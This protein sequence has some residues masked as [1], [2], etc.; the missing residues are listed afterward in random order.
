MSGPVAV[1][2]PTA[3]ND[4]TSLLGEPMD[5]RV[6]TLLNGIG[7]AQLSIQMDAVVNDVD[8]PNY[9]SFESGEIIWVDTIGGAG[10]DTFILTDVSHRGVLG[11]T[12]QPH[13]ASTDAVLGITAET[14]RQLQ[15]AVKAAQ[16]NGFLIGTEAAK[17]GTCLPGEGYLAYDVGKVYVC[18][19]ANTWVWLNQVSHT[20]TT[21]RADD[22]HAQYHTDGR[23][24]TWHG[25]IAED[26][27]VAGDNH[28]HYSANEGPAVLRV[29]GGTEAGKPAA[30]TKGEIYFSTDLD[31][32]TL[33]LSPDGSSWQ[34]ISGMPTGAIGAFD[35]ACPLGWTRFTNLDG[36][37]VRI[38]AAAGGSGGALSHEHDYSDFEQ[39]L[40]NIPFQ[41]TGVTSV[42]SSSHNHSVLHGSAG[43]GSGAK[44][45]QLNV[46][47][48]QN[49]ENSASHT[50]AS[51]LPA[52][53]TDSTG[54]SATT[55]NVNH[56]PPYQEVVFCEKD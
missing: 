36:K 38:T 15:D 19:V 40:H 54:A 35:G 53:W 1:R 34:K 50:H 23:A 8:W 31:G 32:G 9:V 17:P 26:H 49:C 52:Y 11:T 3:Y 39:H 46:D 56:E 42:A 24:D 4:D 20:Q 16:Q 7:I 6:F 30:T 25:L 48:G 10:N 28:D 43:S 29:W 2:Y 44:Y 47:T 14:V 18:Y 22:D 41:D 21:G 55:T 33:W 5:R 27:I 13:S 51:S 12:P 37:Y 45:G